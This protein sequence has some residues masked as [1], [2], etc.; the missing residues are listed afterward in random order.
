MP[1]IAGGECSQVRQPLSASLESL[2]YTVP[3]KRG[4]AQGQQFLL[5][6]VYR[7]TDKGPAPLRS[8]QCRAM[9]KHLA[10]RNFWRQDGS[11][12]G[13]FFSSSS[14]VLWSV[15]RLHMRLPLNY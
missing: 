2:R 12:H 5:W 6:P 1:I 11:R 10:A 9:L 4:N 14:I 7:G 13:S 15:A 3:G 8:R